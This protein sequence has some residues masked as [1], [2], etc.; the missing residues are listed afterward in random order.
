MC[1]C[2]SKIEQEIKKKYDASFTLN[3]KGPFGYVEK[4]RPL[5]VQLVISLPMLNTN[6]HSLGFTLSGHHL[7]TA[8]YCPFCGGSL[9]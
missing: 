8:H 6:D 4:K 2:K 9:C 3:T 7:V 5:D 1:D